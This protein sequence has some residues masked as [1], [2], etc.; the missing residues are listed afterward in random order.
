METLAAL[1]VALPLLVA[2]FVACFAG[3][4]PRR[5]ADL[6]ALATCVAVV[7]IELRLLETARHAPIVA[8][9]GAWLPRGSVSI[10][11][12]L[13]LDSLGLAFALLTAVL[14]FAAVVFALRF[15]DA[16][17]THFHVLLLIFLA[18]LGGLAIA[19]D[20]FNL[21][22]CF[23]LAGAVAYALC[24]YKTEDTAALQGAINFAVSNT[25]GALLVLWGIGLLYGRTGAL[26]LAQMGAAVAGTAPDALLVMGFVLVASGLLVKA[27]MVPFHFWLADAHA[28]APSPVCAIFS[29][30]MVSA[31][32]L[33][34]ARIH[35][36]VFAV[37]FGPHVDA[38]RDV[39]FGFGV[40]TALVG[41]ILCFAQ[42]HFKRLLAFSTIAHV[43]LLVT[44]MGL[45]APAALGGV[46]LYALSHGLVKGALF[47]LAGIVLHRLGDV[48]ELRLRGQGRAVPALG[49]AIAVAALAIAG[50][51][52]TGL[53]VGASLIEEEAKHAG[54]GWLR[55]VFA[56][57][58]V[59]TAAAILRAV[60]R[61][62]CGWG[63]VT[64]RA[65]AGGGQTGET[66]ETFS[67]GGTVPIPMIVAPALLL[68]PGIALGMLPGVE[69]VAVEHAARFLAQGPGAPP[70]LPELAP[71]ADSVPRALFA[72]VLAVGLAAI[73]LAQGRLGD[74]GKRLFEHLERILV[75]PLRLLHSGR[76]GDYVAWEVAGV[77]ALALLCLVLLR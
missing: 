76:I 40:A 51:P 9:M 19:G 31:P 49:I 20:L 72:L 70:P 7:A 21:F 57:T 2:A 12:A 52:P 56:A 60:G 42:R 64:S 14:V 54:Y 73:D 45:F 11:I 69:T 74:R 17:E 46:T 23:E 58:S 61:I 16:A 1:P 27:A 26:N 41:A 62:F 28:V 77:A 55:H 36:T 44:G 4:M 32:I 25:V 50:A 15:F 6:L 10:G 30:V 68:L 38:L 34:L 63:A 13:H 5:I 65:G 33:A 66:P 53:F 43:G 37:P 47:L 35:A 75:R 22:V 24:G 3:H 59:L 29:G 39:F 67:G 8:W 48:D 71:L 18:A